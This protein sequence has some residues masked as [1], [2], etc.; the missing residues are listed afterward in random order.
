MKIEVHAIG[1]LGGIVDSRMARVPFSVSCLNEGSCSS[2]IRGSMNFQVAASIPTTQIFSANT[3]TYHCIL[4]FYADRMFIHTMSL[5][6]MVVI[7]KHICILMQMFK[8]VIKRI[9]KF[10]LTVK[11]VLFYIF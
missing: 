7:F 8:I 2:L 3:I 6:V 1:E 9:Y 11:Y 4:F 10:I 5:R